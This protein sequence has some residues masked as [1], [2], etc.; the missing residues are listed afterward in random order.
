[1]S[2]Q[3][4]NGAAQ[5]GTA[6]TETKVVPTKGT[7]VAPVVEEMK[8]EVKSEQPKQ[9]T[10][11]ERKNRHELFDKL[12]GKHEVYSESRKKM[13]EFIVGSDENSQSLLLK[14][15]KGNQFNTGN[16]VVI[17]E[18]IELVRGKINV[19]CGQ[20]EEEILNFVV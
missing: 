4:S 19:Q 7:T 11:E 14:D 8:P 3:K 15:A 10:V 2:T 5:S 17:K 13:E 16:P 12:L 1:M 6:K 20:V 9:L 18:V